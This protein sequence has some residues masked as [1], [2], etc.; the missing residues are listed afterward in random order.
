MVAGPAKAS[1]RQR[2]L[3]VGSQSRCSRLGEFSR[4]PMVAEVERL[5]YR[6]MEGRQVIQRLVQ[7]GR[8]VFLLAR[9]ART[10]SS[11]ELGKVP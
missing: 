9:S 4:A 8:Q 6:A 10:L 5:Q 3:E 11:N 1:A 7:S 2:C